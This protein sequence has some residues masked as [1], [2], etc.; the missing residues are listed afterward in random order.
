MSNLSIFINDQLVFEYDR[1]T[2]IDDTQREFLDAMDRDMD[3]GIKMSGELISTPDTKQ[4]A[5]FVMMN[6]F[7]ALKQDDNVRLAAYCAY[8]TSRLPHTLEV[9][10]NDQANG[11]AIEFVEEH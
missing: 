2:E 1:S 9:H 7:N 10:A 11:I 8:L 5:T 3:R 4:K 6:L